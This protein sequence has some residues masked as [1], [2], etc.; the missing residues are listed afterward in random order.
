MF[1][2]AFSTSIIIIIITVFLL[3]FNIIDFNS[4]NDFLVKHAIYETLFFFLFLSFPSGFVVHFFQ[5]YVFGTPVSRRRSTYSSSL[6][7]PPITPRGRGQTA[8]DH[9]KSAALTELGFSARKTTTA[10]VTVYAS[11]KS[12]SISA[13]SDSGSSSVY[14]SDISRKSS[15]KAVASQSAAEPASPPPEPVPAAEK[16]I[17]EQ[18]EDI[19]LELPRKAAEEPVIEPSPRVSTDTLES[20]PLKQGIVAS[21][22]AE[23]K[24]A[25]EDSDSDVSGSGSSRKEIV[26]YA[27]Y[28][29]CLR[30]AG[31]GQLHRLGLRLSEAG[32]RILKK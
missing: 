20:A 16:P 12:A 2:S 17:P 5:Y 19:E 7:S 21:V 18:P 3:C 31:Q 11:S 6:E 9:S 10:S 8:S 22:E 15:T 27:F 24:S 32:A 28:V 25:D 30:G 4:T 1:L 29:L 13:D 14:T 26:T 23:D